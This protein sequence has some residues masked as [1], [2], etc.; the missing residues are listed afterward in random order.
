MSAATL[1]Y[2]RAENIVHMSFAAPVELNTREEITAHFSRVLAFWRTHAS[3]QR[4]YFIVD[5]DNLTINASEL[6]F[7]AQESKRAHDVC[8]VASVR[9]GGNPLQRAV[10]RLAG[11]KMQRP[12]NIYE[13]REE[14]LAAV[15]AL[16]SKASA[17][18]R[19]HTSSAR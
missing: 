16:K 14:A 8:A 12:S 9:Y 13:T 18:E 5:F 11:M 10:T 6:E 17:A 19:A 7:Y 2:D 4:S 1:S 15:R 3:G